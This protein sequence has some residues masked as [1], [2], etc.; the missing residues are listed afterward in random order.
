M[1]YEG[2]FDKKILWKLNTYLFINYFLYI[3]L[4]TYYYSMSFIKKFEY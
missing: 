4:P 1:N 3:Y 2:S